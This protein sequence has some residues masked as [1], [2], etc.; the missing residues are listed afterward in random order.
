M[1]NEQINNLVD[2]AYSM[3]WGFFMGSIAGLM[4]FLIW[5]DVPIASIFPSVLTVV[6]CLIGLI[7]AVIQI[8][9]SRGKNPQ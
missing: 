8:A 6:G 4:I 1:T 3:G 9:R 2:V 7:V 5:R